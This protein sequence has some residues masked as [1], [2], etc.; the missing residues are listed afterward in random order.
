MN[1]P[2]AASWPTPQLAQGE[3][4]KKPQEKVEK[5]EKAEKSSTARPHGKEKWMP[6]PYV[7][8]AVFS[9]PLP[10]APRRGSRPTRGG[11]EG[12]G[13]GGSHATAAAPAADKP[14]SSQGTSNAATKSPA[15]ADRG[16]EEPASG[17]ANSLPAQARRSISTD[18]PST[19]EPR[20]SSQTTDRPRGDR[21][22]KGV[23]E[24]HAPL[25][26]RHTNGV[27][28]S[29]RPHR[30][31]KTF[32]RNHEAAAPKSGDNTSRNGLPHS[33][34]HYGSRFG[35]KS[36]ENVRPGDA[37][38]DANGDGHKERE[39]ARESRA[40][41]GRGSYRSRGGH[42]TFGGSQNSQHFG[43][44][45]MSHHNF[46]PQKSFGYN[47]R[48]RAQQQQQQPPQPQ[49]QS[50]GLPNGSQQGHRMSLRSP[51]LPG[52]TGMYAVYPYPADINTMY[53]Y[54][55]VHTAPM[56]AVPYHQ[57]MEPFSLMSMI[58]MQL[59]VTLSLLTLLLYL[60]RGDLTA[61]QGILLFG[62]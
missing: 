25:S 29:A 11:R 31:Y 34:S 16:R 4:K 15:L 35:A 5:P 54:P 20:R 61:G 38:R 36:F 49:Q 26:A 19:A 37:Y 27:D 40:D 32:P 53:A 43:S 56:T 50:H 13:R 60:R 46:V 33:E 18:A 39:Y 24:S 44:T 58:S 41:R 47:D 52:S 59:Y 28:A 9:T 23:D 3:E 6:V 45:H 7:P 51:S 55:A 30:E 1:I 21:V 14:A 2:D 12:A 57:Y 42:A 8:T 10:S 17:R 62:R 22:S 48:Q